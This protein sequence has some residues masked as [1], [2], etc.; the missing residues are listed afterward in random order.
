LCRRHECLRDIEYVLD[1]VSGSARTAFKIFG[2]REGRAGLALATAHDL[3]QDVERFVGV[4]NR[5]L[6][7]LP[8]LLGGY[9]TNPSKNFQSDAA[10]TALPF[11]AQPSSPERVWA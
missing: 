2:S 4:R 5:V 8:A 3:D 1:W 11:S 6:C 7:E 9:F 10:A